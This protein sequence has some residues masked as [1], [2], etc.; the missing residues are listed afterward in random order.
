MAVATAMGTV[1][2]GFMVP[3]TM[4]AGALEKGR[5]MILLV[6]GIK[7]LNGFSAAQMAQGLAFRFA[8][9]IPLEVTLPGIQTGV[10]PRSWQGGWK[11]QTS[12]RP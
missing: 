5:N 6:A 11:I 9:T 7:G 2:P 4:A 3:E 12:G 8:R 1:R 10:P